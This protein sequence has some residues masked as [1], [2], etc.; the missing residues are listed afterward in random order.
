[1][2]D[3]FYGEYF[4]DEEWVKQLF[5]ANNITLSGMCET[6][7]ISKPKGVIPKTYAAM[8]ATSWQAIKKHPKD[9]W[10]RAH[11]YVLHSTNHLTQK[12]RACVMEYM[13]AVLL[14]QE[15]IKNEPIPNHAD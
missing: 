12:Y 9:V 6:L 2:D 15:D 7:G 13:W 8:F 1:M 14:H 10:A 4:K 11:N 5:G 3:E